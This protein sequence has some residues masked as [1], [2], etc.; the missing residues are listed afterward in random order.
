MSNVRS[1]VPG[2]VPDD[3]VNDHLEIP[4]ERKL[5]RHMSLHKNGSRRRRPFYLEFLEDR[6][7]LSTAVLAEPAAEVRSNSQIVTLEG[8]IP[9]GTAQIESTSAT[10]GGYNDLIY[11]MGSGNFYLGN[12]YL[13]NST[14][15]TLQSS[16]ILVDPQ[17]PSVPT[18]AITKSIV[19][20]LT[21][22]VGDLSLQYK[23]VS[24]NDGTGTFKGTLWIQILDGTGQFEGATG[25]GTAVF[26]HTLP[27][28][29]GQYKYDAKF[30]LNVHLG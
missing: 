28:A 25:W 5:R 7:L 22:A 30:D 4:A 20:T 14:L 29:T 2:E 15:E 17:Q 19:A 16:L 11:T 23:G 26:S 1:G 3:E 18:K 8:T 13:G 10:R 6:N 24:T 9:D 12:C 27:D 21:T